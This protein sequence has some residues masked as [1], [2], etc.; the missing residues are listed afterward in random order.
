[1]ADKFCRRR[2]LQITGN[3]NPARIQ[4]RMGKQILRAL[5]V[6]Q[7]GTIDSDNIGME[8]GRTSR[9]SIRAE[10]NEEAAR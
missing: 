6:N 8:G 3:S 5:E 4:K 10:E 1:L 9:R 2:Q 7:A